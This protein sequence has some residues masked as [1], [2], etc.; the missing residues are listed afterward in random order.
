[1]LLVPL[2]VH[3]FVSD[4]IVSLLLHVTITMRL[5][6]YIAVQFACGYVLKLFTFCKCLKHQT[7]VVNNYTVNS[8]TMVVSILNG[9]L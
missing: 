5:W 8:C 1:M 4:V 7:E 2:K 3:S 9:K 6:G